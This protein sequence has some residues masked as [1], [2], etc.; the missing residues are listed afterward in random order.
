M[1]FSDCLSFRTIAQNSTHG[2]IESEVSRN[3]LRCDRWRP[4]VPRNTSVAFSRFATR[5]FETR[6]SSVSFFKRLHS[7]NRTASLPFD[8]LLP[9]Q[10]T[11]GTKPRIKVL[12]IPAHK[13]YRTYNSISIKCFFYNFKRSALFRGSNTWRPGMLLFFRGF[14][15]T[16][17]SAEDGS[18]V[19]HESRECFHFLFSLACNKFPN[20]SFT[21][22]INAFIL[23]MDA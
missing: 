21:D 13:R 1:A 22:H 12:R 17:L 19:A 14:F 11:S 9:V 8:Q 18:S 16:R 5:N 7:S 10:T 3:S 20:L 15:V 2:L 4:V 23:F 6:N